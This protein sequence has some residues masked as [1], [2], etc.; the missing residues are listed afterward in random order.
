MLKGVLWLLC[1]DAAWHDMP[2]SFRSW[3]TTYQWI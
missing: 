1:L 3:P 2:E